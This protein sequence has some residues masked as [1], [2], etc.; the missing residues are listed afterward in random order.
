MSALLIVIHVIVCIALIM[1]VL[2]QTGKGADM[3]AAFGGGA[4]NTLFGS[5]G[6]STFLGKATTAAAII[7]MITS[8]TLAYMSGHRME[9]S[10]M[11]DT[12]VN[13]TMN[14][15]DS[16]TEAGDD[17]SVEG[18]TT[19]TNDQSVQTPQSTETTP[20]DNSTGNTVE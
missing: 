7:F 14:P 19:S 3:G 1:I 5:T 16:G 20:T 2:L 13:Q 10:V 12:K 17:G 8:L 6:A 15:V 11:T 9:G 4:S 18:D